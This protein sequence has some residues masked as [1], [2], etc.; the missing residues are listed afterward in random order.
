MLLEFFLE[1]KLCVSYAWF[2]REKKKD[3][4]F[5]IGENE[6]EIDFMLIKKDHRLIIRIVKAIFSKF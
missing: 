2:K 1:K 3:V 5:R 4:R 6:T